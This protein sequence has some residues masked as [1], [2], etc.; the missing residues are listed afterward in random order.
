MQILNKTYTLTG[1][2]NISPDMLR[3]YVKFFWQDVFVSLHSSNSNIHLN[4][5]CKIG[6]NATEYK[7]MA[8]LRKVN[9]SDR[10]IFIQ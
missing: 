3:S 1:D 6:I 8:P 7:T 10:D 4:L 9:F 5:M 2:N